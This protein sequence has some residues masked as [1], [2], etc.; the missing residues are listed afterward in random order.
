MQKR[1]L[2]RQ[3]AAASV[4]H[5]RPRPISCQAAYAKT[6]VGRPSSRCQVVRAR[7]AIKKGPACAGPERFWE[8]MPERRRGY[9]NGLLMLQVRRECFHTEVL[10]TT[11][12]ADAH[13]IRRRP[14]DRLPRRIPVLAVKKSIDGSAEA[15]S[16][17]VPPSL[18][19]AV[20]NG[21]TSCSQHG[22]RPRRNPNS[23][24]TRKASLGNLR[25]N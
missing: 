18:E 13:G 6:S 4:R 12:I 3:P 2:W 9:G 16:G 1:D 22:G 5:L 15:R 10:G 20:Q 25:Q 17:A 14:R 24:K 8:R 7:A 23:L 11:S 21:S 19:T